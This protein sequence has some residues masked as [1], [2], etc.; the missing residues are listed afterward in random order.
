MQSLSNRVALVTGAS[1][2]IGRAAARLFARAGARVVV[3]AR[4]QSG[5]DALADEIRAEG[6]EAATL[7]GDVREEGYAAALV[8]LAQQRFGRLDVAFNNAGTMGALGPVTG[9]TLA[10]WE[11][12]QATN[13]RSAFLGAKHQIPALLAASGGSLIFTGSFVGHSAGFPGMA[14]Y[15]ASKAGLVGLAQALA[16]E[17]GPQGL[18]V[19]ALLP[20]ATDTPMGRSFMSTPEIHDFVRGLYA[21]KRL[22]QPEEIA[23]AALFLASAASSF[24][25]GTALLVDGGVSVN[26]T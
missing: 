16:T 22:A 23:A 11:E 14:A 24:V 12:V 17:Y 1:S 2:G 10:D 15:A 8:A 19:N 18:R 20:G 3:A 13:L 5:L 9:M 21:L 26:R 25:T 6:G 7:A 4:R